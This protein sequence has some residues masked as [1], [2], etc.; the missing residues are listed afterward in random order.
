MVKR[1][2]SSRGVKILE[3][4]ELNAQQ[5]DEGKQIDQHY[6]AIASKATLLQ[7]D[8]LPAHEA[9]KGEAIARSSDHLVYN[10]LDAFISEYLKSLYYDLRNIYWGLKIFT[11]HLRFSNLFRVI[12]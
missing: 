10:A 9:F 2:L 3:E 11:M 5:I 7:Q 4:G 12:Y 8:Q 6:F 1:E